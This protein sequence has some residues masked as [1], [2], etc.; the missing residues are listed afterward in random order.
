MIYEPKNKSAEELLVAAGFQYTSDAIRG[1]TRNVRVDKTKKVV[2]PK[3]KDCVVVRAWP[4][5]NLP[6]KRRLHAYIVNGIIDMHLDT[7]RDGQHRAGKFGDQVYSC[8]K[9]FYAIDGV[10]V[11]KK[12]D[13][14]EPASSEASAPTEKAHPIL[15][16][17]R[18]GVLLRRI[19]SKAKLAAIVR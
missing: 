6:P 3:A 13:S 19:H 8:I 5:K 16:L 1:W 7:E 11:P 15:F 17:N 12:A 10:E 9:E 14:V 4:N 18:L 2:Q